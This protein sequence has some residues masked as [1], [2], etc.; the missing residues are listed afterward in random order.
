MTIK[1]ICVILVNYQNSQLSIDC[2][3]SLLAQQNDSMELTL[4]IVDN[5]SSESE[6]ELLRVYEKKNNNVCVVYS[7]KNLGY[8]PG[9]KVGQEKAYSLGEYD[10]M[11]LSNNDTLYDES[12]LALLLGKNYPLNTMV[13]SPDIITIDGKHQNPLF[14]KRI[15]RIRKFLYHIYFSNWYVSQIINYIQLK[16]GASRRAKD[17]EGW[18][19]EQIIYIGFGA[20]LIL[21]KLFMDK[22]RF[23]DDRSFLMGEEQLLMIQVEK[24]GGCF[25]YY[26]NMK[27]RHLDSATF[28]KMPSRFSFECMKAGYKLYKDYI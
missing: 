10:Y 23:V 1:K 27:V 16:L 28:K 5:N 8:F 14:I 7:S 18:D 26:P 15:S 9:M 25:Y 17:K 2:C 12:F 3:E 13:V 4:I 11:I 20:C 22:V 6:V 24:A 21:T 19:K